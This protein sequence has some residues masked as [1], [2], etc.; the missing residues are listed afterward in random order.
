MTRRAPTFLQLLTVL[1]A[2][3]AGVALL[4]RSAGLDMP[5]AQAASTHQAHAATPPSTP[6]PPVVHR[7]ETAFDRCPP[8]GSLQLAGTAI[9]DGGHR[10]ALIR[11]P[12]TSRLVTEG[13]VIEG[14]AVRAIARRQVAV[15]KD[16]VRTCLKRRRGTSTPSARPVQVRSARA[17]GPDRYAINRR[18]LRAR[19]GNLNQL[20]KHIKVRP[21]RKDGKLQGFKIV[22]VRDGGFFSRLGVARG[23]VLLAANGQPLDSPN[24]IL[25]LYGQLPDSDVVR[26]RIKRDG[27]IR[28]LDY[29]ID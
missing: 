11:T 4:T 20:K 23:D 19:L 12:T 1:V 8:N 22:G 3:G 25:K 14:H 29:H 15:S 28:T 18:W 21:L 17:I 24:R 7:A 5:R 13:Q 9:I 26:L 6:A 16:A 10:I 27:Q 2:I